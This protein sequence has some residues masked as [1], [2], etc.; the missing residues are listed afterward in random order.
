MPVFLL[1]TTLGV[2]LTVDSSCQK[3]SQFFYLFV[4][5]VFNKLMNKGNT[6]NSLCKECPLRSVTQI[7]QKLAC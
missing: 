6:K 5:F 1:L 2:V 3:I 4:C 7:I